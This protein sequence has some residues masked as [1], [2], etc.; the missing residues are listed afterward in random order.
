MLR[1]PAPCGG[2]E[3]TLPRLA[4][5]HLVVALL[6][7]LC[8]AALS[9]PTVGVLGAASISEGASNPLPAVLTTWAE[10]VERVPPATLR[11]VPNGNTFAVVDSLWLEQGAGSVGAAPA[12]GVAA[13]LGLP[14]REGGRAPTGPPVGSS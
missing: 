6:G 3:G 4:P 11:D 10:V 1:R 9:G 8:L 7:L 14:P 13:G 2:G 5:R 12:L